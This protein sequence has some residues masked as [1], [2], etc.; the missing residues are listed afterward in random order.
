[1]YRPAVSFAARLARRAPLSSLVTDSRL[2]NMPWI[3]V[4]GRLRASLSF[5]LNEIGAGTL[6]KRVVKNAQHTKRTGRPEG[7]PVL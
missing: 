6:S 7:R 5:H 4:T 1:M 2:L 3:P